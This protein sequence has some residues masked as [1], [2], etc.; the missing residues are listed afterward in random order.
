MPDDP[1]IDLQVRD[2]FVAA[3]PEHLLR[4]VARIALDRE[5]LA[6]THRVTVLIADDDTLRA[7]NRD[8][9]DT[10]EVTDVLAFSTR[11]GWRDGRPPRPAPGDEAFPMLPGERDRLGDVAISCPE[12]ARQAK[13]AGTSLDRELALLVAHGILHLLGFDHADPRREAEMSARTRA[14]LAEAFNP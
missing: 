5:R 7:L 11:E 10:D 9:N 12:A 1:R 8:F 3:V 14:I 6:G 13:V 2:E 4:R